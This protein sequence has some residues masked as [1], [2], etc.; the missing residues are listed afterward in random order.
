MLKKEQQIGYVTRAALLNERLLQF[1]RLAVRNKPKPA[2][3]EVS[4]PRPAGVS[5][6][7]RQSIRG[8][9]SR[10]P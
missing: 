5:S 8:V 3:F 6:R 9:V 4:S 1:E 2:H 10:R 7:W